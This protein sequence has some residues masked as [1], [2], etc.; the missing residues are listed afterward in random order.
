MQIRQQKRKIQLLRSVYKSDKKRCIQ[1]LVGSFDV[2]ARPDIELRNKLSGPE[3]D[4]LDAWLRDRDDNELA[5]HQRHILTTLP[6]DM[7][8]LAATT[9]NL[10]TET[11]NAVWAAIAA[12]TKA[13]RKA[14]YK[15]PV[16]VRKA[17]KTLA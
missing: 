9:E 3:L 10:N 7:R 8:V 13:M 5:T 6:V 15:K 4:E 16:A 14:G 11:A 1:E 17:P 2:M 12:L